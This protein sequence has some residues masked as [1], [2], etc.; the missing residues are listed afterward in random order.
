MVI[1]HVSHSRLRMNEA[2]D[3]CTGYFCTPDETLGCNDI[4]NYTYAFGMYM[5]MMYVLPLGLLMF[6]NGNLIK[7]LTAMVC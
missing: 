2:I 7:K 4:Y 3:P 6:F 1:S 5:V